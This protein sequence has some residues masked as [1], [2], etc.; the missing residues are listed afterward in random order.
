MGK[1]ILLR[2]PYSPERQGT[3]HTVCMVSEPTTLVL[4]RELALRQCPRAVAVIDAPGKRSG[5]PA[6]LLPLL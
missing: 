4:A 3:R 5:R 6:G 2:M 1:L